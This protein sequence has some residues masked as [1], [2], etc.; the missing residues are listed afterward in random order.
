MKALYESD[1]FEVATRSPCSHHRIIPECSFQQ[2][3]ALQ[4]IP[5]SGKKQHTTGLLFI[6][7]PIIGFM[8]L[9]TMFWS[10]WIHLYIANF[11]QNLERV[12][13]KVV[14][15]GGGCWPISWL[16]FQS[17]KLTI[18]Q[19]CIFVCRVGGA[20]IWH[21]KG[22]ANLQGPSW[23]SVRRFLVYNFS[24]FFIVLFLTDQPT[25]LFWTRR[26]CSEKSFKRL[27]R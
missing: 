16:L 21:K 10:T 17:S 14:W 20:K 11:W 27:N 8:R 13:V 2:F 26:V 9:G 24:L 25:E 12:V 5:C 1:Y 3:T 6:M 18:F 7:V 23:V 15:E 19:C 22:I 4:S